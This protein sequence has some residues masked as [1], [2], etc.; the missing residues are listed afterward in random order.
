[1]SSELLPKA[2]S[3]GSSFA[4]W[5]QSLTSFVRSS[6]IIES[7]DVKPTITSQGTVLRIKTRAGVS[8]GSTIKQYRLSSIEGD[9]LTCYEWDGTTE[10]TE[11][12]YIARDPELRRSAFE[13]ESVAY[14]SD[15]DAFTATYVY[16]S[17]TKRVKTVSGIAET[18]VIIP[19]Y[20][21]G[22]TV[23]LA[24]E[25]ANKTGVTDPNDE[26]IYLV[27]LTQRAWAKSTV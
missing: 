20:K 12:V 17:N 3:G 21:T 13:G 4:Q 8:A 11:A 2:P 24:A 15:G 19:Y 22:F 26:D 1:M 27:E 5:L 23:I 7:P 25:T 14:S 6:R 9:F 10:G 16:S 18:Q